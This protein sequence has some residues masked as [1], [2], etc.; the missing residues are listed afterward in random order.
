MKFGTQITWVTRDVSGEGTWGLFYFTET[1]LKLSSECLSTHII[2]LFIHLFLF[3]ESSTRAGNKFPA[4]ENWEIA[5]FKNEL[6]EN[7]MSKE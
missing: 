4:W 5:S 6:K 1:S 3:Q 2:I 7:K